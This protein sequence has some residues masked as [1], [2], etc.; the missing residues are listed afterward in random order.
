MQRAVKGKKADLR[1]WIHHHLVQTLLDRITRGA[2]HTTLHTEGADIDDAGADA[3]AA[4][5]PVL[6]NQ[7]A[8]NFF[9][10]L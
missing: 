3:K 4:E 6:D 2:E 5:A 8:D 7:L 1:T 9:Q 10:S